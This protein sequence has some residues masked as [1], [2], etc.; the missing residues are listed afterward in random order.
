MALEDCKVLGKHVSAD[1]R[2]GFEGQ[3][4]QQLPA[5]KGMDCCLTGLES[6]V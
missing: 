6:A 2:E 5:K 4:R 1:L 3:P